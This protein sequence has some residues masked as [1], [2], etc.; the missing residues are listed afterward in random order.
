MGKIGAK[1]N[2]I[3]NW[4]EN[5]PFLIMSRVEFIKGWAFDY[6]LLRVLCVCSKLIQVKKIAV[7]SQ[8]FTEL[9]L[10]WLNCPLN[11]SLSRC[12]LLTMLRSS[13]GKLYEH[14]HPV[15]CIVKLKS[16]NYTRCATF[17]FLSYTTD[18][19]GQGRGSGIASV[20]ALAL[21]SIGM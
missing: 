3:S 21:S 1:L 13:S 11:K 9:K 10:P 20:G 16:I 17:N 8:L 15:P 19:L 5:C 12:S 18:N 2:L 4:S 7:I 6:L 14:S